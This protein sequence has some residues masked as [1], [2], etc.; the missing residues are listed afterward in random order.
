M[1]THVICGAD[2][3]AP[4]AAGGFGVLRE[5]WGV[6][7]FDFAAGEVACPAGHGGRGGGEEEQRE[8]CG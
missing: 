6:V 1:G 7:F 3:L 4:A 8:T 5:A 2:I